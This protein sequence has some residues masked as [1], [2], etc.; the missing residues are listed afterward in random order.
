M[1]K[2]HPYA[3]DYFK[4]LYLHNLKI[5]AISDTTPPT[6]SNPAQITLPGCNGSFPAP[7]I[8]V[9]TDEAD[10]CG[11]PTVAFVGDGTP[12][13]VGCLETTIR[14]YSVTDACG[15]AIN[16]TQNLIRT[17]DAT[18]PTASNPAQITL[19]GCNGSFPAPD[20]TVV[21][22]EADNCGT[23]TVAFV[24]DGTPSLVG[25]LETTIRTY[26]VTDACGNA[27]NVTQN[28]IRT[29]DATPPTA[30]NPAQ[31]TLPGCNGS[32][33]APDITVVTD[34]AD[35]CGTPTVAFVGDGTPS[36]VGCLETTIRTYSVTDACG[37]AIN[38]TQNLIRTV[39]ATPPTASN[40]AQITLP[41]CNGSFPAPD[42]TVVT[43]EADNCGT[44]T[45]AFV[46]DGTPS[47][48]GCLE[49]TI[50]TYSVTDACGNA[51]NVTQNLIRTVDATPPTASNPAQITLPGCNG[52]FPAP[53]ITVVTDEADNCGTPTVAFV[54]DGTPSLVGCLETT[55]R[56]YSVTDACGNAINVTQNL[57]RT[58]DATP[59]TASNPAQITL[60]GCNGSF[61]APDITVVTDE[62]DNCGTPTVAFVGDGTPSIV[63]CLETTIR[64][65]SVT[66]AC[67]NA[68]NVTQ[69]LIR[70]VDATPPT[71]S[72]PAQITL[73]GCNGSFP[74]PDITVV[75]D[76]ADN[77]GTPTVAFVGDGTPSIVGCLETTIRTYS[78]TDACGN[79]INVTQN[80]I[81]TVDATPPT[82]SNP[83]QITLPGC[84]GSFPAP[85]ITVVTDEAD[86]CG[87]PTVAFVGDGTPSI[88]GC[89]ETT[90]R[91]YSV[92]D[93]C[94]N[95]I[96]V[97]QNLIRTVDATPPTA[98]NP[99]QITLPGCNGSFPAPDITVV[100]D[101][102]DNCGT[103]T[104]AFVGDGTP[105]IV[106][107]L[108]TTIRT[109]SVTDACGNAINVTQN[110][111]RTVDATPPTASNP[112]QITL[113]GC[114]G[115]F[116][117]PDITV[118]T[119]EA[120]NCGTPTVAFVGD[121]TPSLV[122]CLETTIRT[123][124]VTDACGNAINVTQNLIRTVDATP[125][126]ASN[127]AQITLPGCNGSFPAPD[128]TVVTDEADNCGT[129]TVAF[130][131]RWNTF[132]RRMP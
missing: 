58:V 130:V 4:W 102:A 40:P 106:G 54:G 120:D 90:I 126:T 86:N 67:G 13:L 131:G 14:T 41:G 36:L 127:P 48:V 81:R 128:I 82:A 79:A 85:D 100:T 115:S 38:V 51:I 16:V 21:T 45:V 55:I 65:Y 32:F 96:N 6:A 71:A 95:A 25:C 53:D 27:I 77:C 30:S 84:N 33:P 15:N 59:P 64:T 93:A 68:I 107:C 3:N 132:N 10:N 69:N 17:V 78:V 56:T 72:N 108:E 42:I 74:A 110:L 22:D 92:T 80:L 52:S 18:P 34:E 125:P 8:T 9:V 91:T 111:I 2:F 70:T 28:L 63:G 62:A 44:P 11:T 123:Y 99:A 39:D 87:T 20:I 113:P 94:G 83:A 89:L 75:T 60:P 129:P 76:E 7:D 97:T 61:P 116:P 47:L 103:P 31:I 117:A 26:S 73:P 12:S 98:S 118:V 101:E 104:V 122:G 1:W 23:P 50:R 49:T 114:N 88:V 66:D 57:I 109:Y 24:G 112:A 43:D 37:N 35:N 105:S 19:P 29:V 124:S 119:D 46:G 5:F 121:G